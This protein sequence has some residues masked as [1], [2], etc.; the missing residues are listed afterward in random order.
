[1]ISF[2]YY[3]YILSSKNEKLVHY[4]RLLDDKMAIPLHLEAEIYLFFKIIYAYSHCIP[5][6]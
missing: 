1:M 2:L 3:K 4:Y 6:F 5:I